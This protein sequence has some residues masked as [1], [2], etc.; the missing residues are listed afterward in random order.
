MAL[1]CIRY[2]MLIKKTKKEETNASVTLNRK[3][4]GSVQGTREF[5]LTSALNQDKGPPGLILRGLQ[6]KKWQ[7]S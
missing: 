5:L 7:A 4:K 3:Q 6:C 2:Y 1:I